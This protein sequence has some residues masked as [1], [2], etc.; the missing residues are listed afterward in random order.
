MS[1][2]LVL[3]RLLLVEPLWRGTLDDF[4]SMNHRYFMTK[5]LTENFRNDLVFTM[6]NQTSF[7]SYGYFLE[8]GF[9][10][11]YVVH[12]SSICCVQFFKLAQLHELSAFRNACTVPRPEQWDISTPGLSR[13]HGCFN[14]IGLW[15][16]E[17]W[18]EDHRSFLVNVPTP[19]GAIASFND[20]FMVWWINVVFAQQ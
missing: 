12:S 19:C 2:W 3:Y 6:T 7:P 18:R 1:V 13:M 10:T 15:F 20:R 4:C 17:V 9:T 5:F 11:W 14:A 16:L 8:Q